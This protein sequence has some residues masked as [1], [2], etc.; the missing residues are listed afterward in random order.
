MAANIRA[1]PIAYPRDFAAGDPAATAGST[2]VAMIEI[3]LSLLRR[4]SK[5]RNCWGKSRN[6]AVSTSQKL[7][8]G[9]SLKSDGLFGWAV[10]ALMWRCPA[11]HKMR[12]G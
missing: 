5:V 6:D 9:W 3:V 10:I 11:I 1:T 4:I 8:S 2:S 12:F 7:R